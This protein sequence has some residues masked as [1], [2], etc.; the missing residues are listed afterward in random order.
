MLGMYEIACAVP[1]WDMS[2]MAD[3]FDKQESA[4]ASALDIVRRL[5]AMPHPVSE[6]QWTIEAGVSSSFFSNLRGTP[7]KAPADPSVSLLRRV[8]QVRGVSLPEFFAD[9]AGGK[10][11]PVAIQQGLERAFAQ[12]LDGLP[13]RAEDQPRYLATVVQRLLALPPRQAASERDAGGQDGDDIAAGAPARRA[14]R[15]K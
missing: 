15:R 7:T 9:E 3:K 1:V 8:L 11:L 2:R 6:R 14:S 4:R 12:A 10:L 13:A 5:E